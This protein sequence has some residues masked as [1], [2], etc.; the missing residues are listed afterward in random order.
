MKTLKQLTALLLSVLLLASVSLMTACG[1]G[2]GEGTGVD[3]EVTATIDEVY[4][5]VSAVLPNAENLIDAQSTYLSMFFDG[6]TAEDFANHKIVMQS[7][8]TSIDNVGIFEAKTKEDVKKIEAMIDTYLDF[9]EN[10]VWDDTYLEEEFPKLQNAER[11]TMGKYVMYVILD[12]DTRASAITA[13][14]NAC[15]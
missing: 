13:F 2:E 1:G 7:M 9:Y 10:T 4:A 15:K 12:A 5:A 11:V 14:E 6:A 3:F 8:S